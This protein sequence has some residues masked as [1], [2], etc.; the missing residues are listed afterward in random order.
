MR[1]A[2][3]VLFALHGIAHGVGFVASWRLAELEEMPY[4]TTLLAGRVDV[5]DVGVRTMGILWLVAGLTF[6]AVGLSVWRR[7]AWWPS[8]AIGV[9]LF[10]LVLCVLGWP[11]SRIGVAVNVAILVLLALGVRLGWLASA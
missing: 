11:D 6:L 5:G 7:Q 8:L 2:L 9:T 1:I 10:S 3:A 4:R